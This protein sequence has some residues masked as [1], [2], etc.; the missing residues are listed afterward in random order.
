[1]E[2]GETAVFEGDFVV[3]ADKLHEHVADEE[4]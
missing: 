1:M 3:E 4:D 2:A